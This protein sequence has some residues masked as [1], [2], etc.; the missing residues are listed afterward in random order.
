MIIPSSIHEVLLVTEENLDNI[1]TYN[2]MVREVNATQVT[3]E[4]RLSDHVYVYS[5]DAGKLLT[6]TEYQALSEGEDIDH[7][8]GIS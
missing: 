7:F 6:D 4:E 1:E 8:K 2:Q 3:K 5:V